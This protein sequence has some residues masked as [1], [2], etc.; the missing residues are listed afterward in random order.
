MYR[1]NI[2]ENGDFKC[3]YHGITVFFDVRSMLER[4]LAEVPLTALCRE[5]IEEAL[6]HKLDNEITVRMLHSKA[7]DFWFEFE[8]E[9]QV[10]FATIRGELQSLVDFLNNGLGVYSHIAV[11][12]KSEITSIAEVVTYTPA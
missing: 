1:N 6:T 7:E 12:L 4:V 11:P 8:I 10:E 5:E 3:E 2:T 9:A